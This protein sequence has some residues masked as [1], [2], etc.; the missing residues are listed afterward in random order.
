MRGPRPTLLSAIVTML[1]LLLA[2][3]SPAVSQQRLPVM[4]V[5]LTSP[6][7]HGSAASITVKTT[8]Q[9]ACNITVT[10]KS[11]PS[12]AKGLA[13]KTADA[14]GIVSWSWMVGTRT[15]PGTWPIS[16]NCSGG[17]RQGTL[18]IAFVVT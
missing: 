10:Y 14:Q 17:G 16:V 2:G 4:L 3:V 18:E 7:S 11:G 5:A 8:P 6:V 12:R 1:V 13:P 9:A 15:T